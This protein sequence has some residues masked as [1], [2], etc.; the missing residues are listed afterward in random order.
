MAVHGVGRSTHDQDLLTL[1][2]EALHP[3]TWTSLQESGA[4]A[5]IRKGDLFDPL[6]GVIRF[7]RA[8]ER[9][10]DLVVGRFGWQREILERALPGE[11]PVVRAADL[12]LLKL[13]AGGPQDAW[14]I[15]QILSGDDRERLIAEVEREIPRLPQAAA[16]FWR[17]VLG[18]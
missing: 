5:E 14:D 16:D 3:E 17:R 4:T 2:D 6:A 10:V 15:Q 8:G 13:Y 7:T 12:I 1:G 11:I 18:G 9:P